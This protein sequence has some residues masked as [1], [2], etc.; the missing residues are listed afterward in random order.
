M[1]FKL[2]T[3]INIRLIT[4]ISFLLFTIELHFISVSVSFHRVFFFLTHGQGNG[5]ISGQ[6][7]Q[8]PTGRNMRGLLDPDFCINLAGK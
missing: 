5:S 3:K 2:T 4:H 7:D 1:F 6:L 8:F